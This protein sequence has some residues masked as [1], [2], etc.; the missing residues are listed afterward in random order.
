MGFFGLF[1]GSSFTK[2][3]PKHGFIKVSKLATLRC[4]FLPFYGMWWIKQTSRY[5]FIVGFILYTL[6][7]INIFIY[8]WF[9]TSYK[10]T[11]EVK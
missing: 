3:K 4:I 2:A 1:S 9:T 11:T 6:L 5:I 8:V 10:E 7:I